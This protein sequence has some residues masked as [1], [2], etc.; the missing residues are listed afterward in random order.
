MIGALVA[1]S[2]GKQ[3]RMKTLMA[4]SANG[5]YQVREVNGHQFRLTYLPEKGKDQGEWCFKLNVEL[6]PEMKAAK[7][8]SQQA[9]FGVD[10]LFTLISGMDTIIPIHAM[11]VANGNMNGVEY[12][13]I[14][15]KK[16]WQAENVKFCFSDWLFTHQFLEFPIQMPAINKIDSISSRI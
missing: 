5:L 15:E 3:G 8:E 14:F 4:D 13:V 2:G 12:M 9:S 6:S 16:A 11:R 1:C 10:T 7:G